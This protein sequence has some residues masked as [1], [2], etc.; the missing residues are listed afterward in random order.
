MLEWVQIKESQMGKLLNTGEILQFAI[1]IEQEGYKFYV[2]TMKKMDEAEILKLFQYLADE[3][4]KHEHIFKN[5]LEKTGHSTPPETYRGEYEAYM[6]DFLKSSIFEK[7]RLN[8]ENIDSIQTMK[9]A[10]DMAL[11][12]EKDSIVFYSALKRYLGEENQSLIDRI[13]AEELNHISRITQ[14]Q[15]GLRNT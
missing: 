12:F 7:F 9:N 4:F 11:D 14:Y 5:L 10:I 6:Q 8:Q 13:I 15:Q 3:E 2:Q 1:K